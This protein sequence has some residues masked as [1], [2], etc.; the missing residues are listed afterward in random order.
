MLFLYVFKNAAHFAAPKYPKRF[1]NPAMWLFTAQ[2][3]QKNSGI[4]FVFNS[5]ITFK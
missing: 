5:F 2:A 1:V 4:C 3:H